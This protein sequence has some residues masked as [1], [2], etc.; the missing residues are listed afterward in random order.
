GVD[1]FRLHPERSGATSGMTI[2]LAS[3]TNVFLDAAPIWVTYSAF[4]ANSLHLDR[5]SGYV[6]DTWQL[7]PNLSVTYGLRWL[8]EP[9]PRL[10]ADPNLYQVNRSNG[11]I[12]YSTPAPGTPIWQ[13]R[14]L[15]LDPAASAAWR[16]PGTR[17]TVLRISW[18]TI[19]DASFGVATDQL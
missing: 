19:H 16:L 6:Q 14:P 7:T 5:V 13:A 1:W 9:P 12:R 3:P 10:V 11:Q 15:D 18:A 17:E 8:H 4:P 2:A